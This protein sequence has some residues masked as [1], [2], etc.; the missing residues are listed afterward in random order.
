MGIIKDTYRF[1][2]AGHDWRVEYATPSERFAYKVW[3]D[4]ELVLEQHRHTHGLADMYTPFTLVV[5]SDQGKLDFTIGQVSHWAGACEVSQDGEVLYRTSPKP[6]FTPDTSKGVMGWVER[7]L[8]EDGKEPDPEEQAKQERAKARL[9]S[10]AVDLSMAVV[11]FIIARE[12]G[13]TTAALTGA[14]VTLAL[15][16]VQ[17]FVKVDLLGGFAVFGVVMALISAGLAMAFDNELF[18]KLR[19]SVVGVIG[20]GFA[21]VDAVFN[22]GN[23]LGARMAGYMEQFVT[24]RPQRAAFAMA[25]AGLTLTAIDTPLAFI[26]TTDQWIWYNAFLDSLIA[27]PIVMTAMWLARER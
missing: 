12:F 26:L 19:G 20:A 1:T 22:R 25:G 6:F 21:L 11:F 16:V 4:G 2:A 15:F 18:I 3:R 14:G 9:P 8:T 24:L 5:D 27:I 13:L 10:I 7:T 23:Y 17:R